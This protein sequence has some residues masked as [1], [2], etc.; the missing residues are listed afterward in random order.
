MSIIKITNAAISG[1]LLDSQIPSLA[2]SKITS[3]TFA[4]ARIAS[5][6]VSQHVT[7][8]D[9]DKIVNDL[10][11][12]GLRVH[13]QENLSASNTNSASFDT[14]QDS[15]A[16]SNLTNTSRDANEFMSSTVFADTSVTINNSNYTTYIDSVKGV[17]ASNTLRPT[18]SNELT[19]I[20]NFDTVTDNTT[21]DGTNS[22]TGSAHLGTKGAYLFGN[23]GDS[24]TS[25]WRV[26]NNVAG[27]AASNY[28]FHTIL[29]KLNLT[30]FNNEGFAIRD[31]SLKWRN[32]SGN[33]WWNQMY[34]SVDVTGIDTSNE[35]HNSLVLKSGSGISNGTS[36]T[37]SSDG[38]AQSSNTV[39]SKLIIIDQF[40]YNGTNS[41]M[42]DNLTITGLAP[43]GTINA[44]GSF[45]G[46]NITASSTNKMGAVITYQDQA[47][48]N[49]LNTDIVLQLSADGGSN[50]STATLTALPDFAT[51]IK[52]AKVNDL[53]VTAGTS[54]TYKIS[55]A[56]Q[57][58]G[59]KEARIRGVS[60]QF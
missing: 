25:Y 3:G 48:T 31:Y 42:F 16:V 51:G 47:G 14:F 58:S 29:L 55:F 26:N 53:S 44:S 8:F 32:G 46:N 30:A 40:H 18:G 24:D 43:V 10:S 52:M 11:T 9:D 2:T 20:T 13:T 27:A 21:Y 5:S 15:T 38:T 28:Y 37:A 17:Q 22:G 39:K 12:L 6:N 54:L 49:A 41:Y 34:G 23:N 7:A 35:D 60:L 4:D 33:F 45:T 56:N 50:F 36:Y 19:A 1:S 59:S 57:S